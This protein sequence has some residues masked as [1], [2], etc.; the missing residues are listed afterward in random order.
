[1]GTNQGRNTCHPHGAT[2]NHLMAALFY[3]GSPINDSMF[4]LGLI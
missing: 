4:D 1:V 3:H 2:F